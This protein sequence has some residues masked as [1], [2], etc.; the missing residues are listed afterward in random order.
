MADLDERQ[1]LVADRADEKTES[2]IDEQ[3]WNG[4]G[5]A[6]L[7]D[8][9]RWP[10]RFIVLI[11]TCFLNFGECDKFATTSQRLKQPIC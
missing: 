10:H 7:C 8:P 1:P 9:R 11:F 2:D 4:C 6:I 3:E 5:P